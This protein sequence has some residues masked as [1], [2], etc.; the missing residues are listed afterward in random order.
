MDQAVE[1]SGH[2]TKCRN[3]VEILACSDIEPLVRREQ[4]KA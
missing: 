2:E 4:R 3:G 1:R